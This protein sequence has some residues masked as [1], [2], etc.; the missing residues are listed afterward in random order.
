MSQSEMKILSHF[1]YV[2][3]FNFLDFSI[4][5][6]YFDGKQTQ[7]PHKRDSI[8]KSKPLMLVHSH[9]CSPIPT[10]SLGGASYFVTFMDD[11][12]HKVWAYPLK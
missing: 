7:S 10:L 6:H 8:Q 5:K 4:C 3:C 9:V 1:G 2:L 12:S 11:F